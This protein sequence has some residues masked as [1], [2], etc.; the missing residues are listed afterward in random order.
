MLK[1]KCLSFI[2]L[3][4]SHEMSGCSSRRLHGKD[5][6]DPKT[7]TNTTKLFDVL[8]QQ[9]LTPKPLSLLLKFFNSTSDTD[10][11]IITDPKEQNTRSLNPK[12]D[13]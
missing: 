13:Q 1:K 12:N 10:K 8:L 7:K 6:A 3:Y 9:R 5:T 11:L 2:S 4:K